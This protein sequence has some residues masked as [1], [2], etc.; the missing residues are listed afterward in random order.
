MMPLGRESLGKIE[1]KP[2][3]KTCQ[4]QWDS[5]TDIKNKMQY[6]KKTRAPLLVE[7]SFLLAITVTN[8][9]P[10]EVHFLSNQAGGL[11][12]WSYMCI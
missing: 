11:S 7:L 4:M 9:I 5:E 10:G 3:K 12:M 8:W 2:K 6:K 1:K